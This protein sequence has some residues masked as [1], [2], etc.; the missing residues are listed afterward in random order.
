M[1]FNNKKFSDP[2]L[3]TTQA[4][5]YRWLNYMFGKKFHVENKS[6][7]NSILIKL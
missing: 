1:I 6:L 5:L 7:I 4:Y 3:Y 2:Q